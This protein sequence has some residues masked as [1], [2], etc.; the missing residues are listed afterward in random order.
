MKNRVAA[1]VIL[2]ALV[3]S[4]GAYGQAP[5]TV[6]PGLGPG[7]G[8]SVN[9]FDPAFQKQ[10][11]IKTL[12]AQADTANAAAQA[13]YLLKSQDWLVNAVA[14]RDAGQPIPPI[15][16]PPLKIHVD[17]VSGAQTTGPDAVASKPVLPA[18]SGT[19]G[20]GGLIASQNPP[21][22]R[23]DAITAGLSQMW[24]MISQIQTDIKQIKAK[25]GVQ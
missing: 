21:P 16:D 22:D 14:A 19:P 15:S 25:L 5:V 10:A 2:I 20:T 12:Q 11:L 24:Q 8:Q 13:A 17:P 23:I 9:P 3:L 6:V 7:L 18:P 4:F 1:F